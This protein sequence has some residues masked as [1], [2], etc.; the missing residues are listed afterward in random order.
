MS[1]FHPLDVV[2]RGSEKQHEVSEHLS[3]VIECFKGYNTTA[4][5]NN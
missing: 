3:Y 4:L 2:D 1:N 5:S